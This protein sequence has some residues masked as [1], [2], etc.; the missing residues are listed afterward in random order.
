MRNLEF[1]IFRDPFTLTYQYTYCTLFSLGRCTLCFSPSVTNAYYGQLILDT[2]EIQCLMSS[3]VSHICFVSSIFL[4]WPLSILEYYSSCSN[5]LPWVYST[6]HN[7]NQMNC[8]RVFQ[9]VAWC[10]PSSLLLG[11][12]PLPVPQQYHGHFYK[13]NQVSNVL[14][15]CF[16]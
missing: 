2:T 7:M 3:R 4:S 1:E 15:A 10:E 13:I 11:L 9:I 5:S 12:L 6:R 16:T 8:S 14:C